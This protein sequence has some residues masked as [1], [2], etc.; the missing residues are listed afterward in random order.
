MK[1]PIFTDR[2]PPPGGFYSQAIGAGPFIFISGQ[3]PLDSLGSVVGTNPEEQTIQALGNVEA[4]LEEAGA[5]AEHLVSVTV[6]VSS[7]DHWPEVN[8]AY[9]DYLGQLEIPPARAVVPAGELHHGAMIEIAAI[10]YFPH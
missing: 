8:R 9:Q 10:A 2:A 3:L 6:Y 5:S 7:I 1:I 4:I